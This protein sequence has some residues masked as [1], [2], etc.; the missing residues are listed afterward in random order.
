[1]NEY[2]MRINYFERVINWYQD[3]DK[4]SANDRVIVQYPGY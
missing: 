3:I 1:M 4:V 2:K